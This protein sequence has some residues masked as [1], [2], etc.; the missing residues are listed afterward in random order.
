MKITKL[1]LLVAALTF[2][3]VGCKGKPFKVEEGLEADKV[4]EEGEQL[5]LT[6][7]KLIQLDGG[8]VDLLALDIIFPFPLRPKYIEAT[9]SA[10]IADCDALKEKISLVK[11]TTPITDINIACPG[12]DKLQIAFTKNLL[13]KTE[14]KLSIKDAE[15]EITLKTMTLGDVNGDGE[16]DIVAGKPSY[17]RIRGAVRAFSGK[18]L[19]AIGSATPIGPIIQ[20]EEPA[21][22]DQFG[23]SVKVADING[24][25]FADI[26]VG[27]PGKDRRKGAVAI[28][29]G[30]ELVINKLTRIGPLISEPGLTDMASFGSS[31][32]VAD[33][34]DD[35]A[36]DIIAGAP[37]VNDGAGMFYIY[38]GSE[39]LA[40]KQTRIAE[41]VIVD[42]IAA[43]FG[44]ALAVANDMNNDG[45]SEIIVGA[46]NYENKGA[47]FVYN[48]K[49]L[50]AGRLIKDSIF[51]DI[52]GAM[53]G[54]SVAGGGDFNG[55]NVPD[56]VVGSPEYNS[57]HGR[58]DIYSGADMS[59]IM[60]FSPP[61]SARQQF[62]YAV[63]VLDDISGDGESEVV[64]GAP[65]F[66]EAPPFDKEKGA[67]GAFGISEM[68]FLG[69][70]KFSAEG[71]QFGS[72]LAPAGDINGD[73][74]P[75]II[76]GAHLHFSKKGA[77]GVYSGKELAENNVVRIGP[78]ITSADE[79]AQFG[80]SVA[81][82]GK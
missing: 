43:N 77:V 76:V 22:N 35:G 32:A 7:L 15:K 73:G 30:E 5:S 16:P 46:P 8:E 19:A 11:D 64:V 34:N 47:V 58:F 24:D 78:L 39:L 45:I 59:P 56:V 2:V 6:A 75:D 79:N 74:Y 31:L 37:G 57:S 10:P 55:D 12:E 70:I 28:Y 69:E 18:E 42:M 53:F 41:S 14:Y 44:A 27:I 3:F 9:Y 17:D 63:A 81:G 51:S 66:D 52:E 13:P 49:E 48:G 50:A 36:L 54:F 72:S 33:L 21:D 60:H 26:A 68:R 4:P 65:L 67:V 23:W 25:G 61:G 62:G 82:G 40:D 20:L 29:S 38:S 1:V 71:A 80:F